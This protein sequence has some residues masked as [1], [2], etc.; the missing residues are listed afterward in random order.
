ML[1]ASYST[2]LFNTLNASSSNIIFFEWLNCQVSERIKL[3]NSGKARMYD[4]ILLDI[5]MPTMDGD[6]AA[7]E[8]RDLGFDG[9]HP[10]PL[11]QPN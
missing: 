5:I 7:K 8:I 10:I 9:D 2:S 11:S 3:I 6:V 4:A 1:S